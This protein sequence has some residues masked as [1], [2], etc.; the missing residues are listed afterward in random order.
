MEANRRAVKDELNAEHVNSEDQSDPVA[1]TP[2]AVVCKASNTSRR[3]PT[4]PD[5]EARTVG[6]P[7]YVPIPEQ[8]PFTPDCTPAQQTKLAKQIQN[9]MNQHAKL[10]YGGPPLKA[11]PPVLVRPKP[12][13]NG[14]PAVHPQLVNRGADAQTQTSFEQTRFPIELVTPQIF[15]ESF[16][17]IWTPVTYDGVK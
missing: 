13:A 3:Q 10:A 14:D 2:K 11:P 6:A 1:T 15:E 7:G 16:G 17:D 12:N 8:F 5:A 4:R 9:Y